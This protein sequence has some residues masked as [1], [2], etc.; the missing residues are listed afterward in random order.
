MECWRVVTEAVHR[1]AGRIVLVAAVTVLLAGLTLDGI[2]HWL[3]PPGSPQAADAIVVLGGDLPMR[4]LRGYELY[5]QGLAPELWISAEV[6]RPGTA[7]MAEEAAAIVRR[8]GVPDGAIRL[9]TPTT[10]TWE[11]GQ[12]I[13][14][15]AKERAVHRLL[16]V[17]SWYHGRRA[18][19]VFRRH[20]AGSGISVS[21]VPASWYDSN[22]WWGHRDGWAGMFRELAA[23]GFYWLRHGL[24]PWNC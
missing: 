15:L 3:N 12:E 21:Y 20:L 19:C 7:S 11:E 13:A 9:T 5:Q 4:V 8:R 16:L 23:L 6:P 1:H 22:T 10:S 24:A 14:A 2:A 18:L 17:T